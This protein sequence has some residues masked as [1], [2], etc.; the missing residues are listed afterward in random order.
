MYPVVFLTA[1]CGR[2]AYQ[3]L[4]TCL[5]RGLLLLLRSL[6]CFTIIMMLI[7]IWSMSFCYTTGWLLSVILGIIF[8]NKLTST[9][10]FIIATK[11]HRVRTF[12]QAVY[13]LGKQGKKKKKKM[14]YTAYV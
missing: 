1:S 8:L 7:E 2:W 13:Y 9:F 5:A 12:W 14:L 6:V 4:T 3:V 10:I 11:Y